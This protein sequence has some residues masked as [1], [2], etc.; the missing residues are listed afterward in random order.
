MSPLVMEHN[1]GEA[2]LCLLNPQVKYDFEEKII[3][4]V[5]CTDGL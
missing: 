3:Y 1:R 2:V 4:M 5:N